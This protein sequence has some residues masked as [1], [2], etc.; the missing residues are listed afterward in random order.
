MD[1][2]NRPPADEFQFEGALNW[3]LLSGSGSGLERRIARS[4]ALVEAGTPD[5]RLRRTLS[6]SPLG[7]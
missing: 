4:M 3:L 5:E 2:L 6:T 7:S 1:G